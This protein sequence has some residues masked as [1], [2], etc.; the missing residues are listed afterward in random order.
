MKVLSFGLDILSG[1][2]QIYFM[3]H[4][5]RHFTIHLENR[6]GLYNQ[7]TG[8][9]FAVNH[10]GFF[11]IQD[12][13]HSEIPLKLPFY[14]RIFTVHFSLYLASFSHNYFRITT[15]ISD[16]NTIYPKISFR[17]YTALHFCRSRYDIVACRSLPRR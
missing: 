13:R 10:C 17:F 7:F 11:H 15:Q 16:K 8:D 1:R 2:C 3:S 14:H 9:N 4:R 12:I 5:I 6:T